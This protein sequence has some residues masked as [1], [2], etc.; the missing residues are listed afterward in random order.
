MLSM[1][2]N[3]GDTDKFLEIHNHPR[4]YQEKGESMTDY[5]GNQNTFKNKILRPDDFISEV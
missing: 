5:Q 2:N 1:L 4:L 3:L